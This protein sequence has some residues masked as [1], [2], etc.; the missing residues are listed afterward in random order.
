MQRISSN[1]TL[2][3]KVFFPTAWITFFSLLTIAVIFSGPGTLP[4]GGG[5]GFKI[6]FVIGF[7]LFFAFLYFTV[8]KLKRVD[9]GEDGLYISNYI[10]TY[11]YAFNDIDLIDETNMLLFTLGKIVL[12]EKGSFG[13]KIFFLISPVH[14]KDILEKY[15][16]K[17]SHLL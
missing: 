13:K 9:F 6:T 4:F 14:F 2:F 10:K 1:W 3:L 8:M 12:K 15:P 5:I 17:F 7:L 16:E 11:R